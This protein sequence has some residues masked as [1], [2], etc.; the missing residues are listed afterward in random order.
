MVVVGSLICVRATKSPKSRG[1][2][3][4]RVL[5]Y[6]RPYWGHIAGMLVTILLSTGVSLVSPLIFRTMIDKVLPSKNLN[7]LVLLAVALLVL[8]ILNG[9]I[10]VIQRR[11]NSHSRRRRHLRPARGAL[12]QTAAHEPALLHQHQD[13]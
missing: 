1:T 7:Q 9:G 10:S 4:V 5:N 3:L 11:L 8:P 13:R 12:R 2:L 6:A